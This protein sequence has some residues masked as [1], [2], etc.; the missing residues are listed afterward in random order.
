[1]LKHHHHHHSTHH[2]QPLGMYKNFYHRLD[3]PM[4]REEK[5]RPHVKKPLQGVKYVNNDS[6][7]MTDIAPDFNSQKITFKDN[8]NS[9][10]PSSVAANPHKTGHMHFTTKAK[11]ELLI[12]TLVV[13]GIAAGLLFL[14]SRS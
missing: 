5:L 13:V 8:D 6:K 14:N 3:T 7:V 4:H 9:V 11:D 1:M 12:S 2:W 10:L